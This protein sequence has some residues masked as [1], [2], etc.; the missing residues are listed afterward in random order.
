MLRRRRA[1]RRVAE[2]LLG[3]PLCYLAGHFLIKGFSA[4]GY[5]MM[6]DLGF[7]LLCAALLFA[8]WLLLFWGKWQGEAA[9]TGNP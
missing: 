8:A 4:F 5:N 7:I 6:R 3:A 9:K 2:A 1:G